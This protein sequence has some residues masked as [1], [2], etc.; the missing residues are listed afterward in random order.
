MTARRT[1]SDDQV[2]RRQDVEV[3]AD[4]VIRRVVEHRYT[5]QEDHR[6]Q[7]KR[8]WPAD[9]R[10]AARQ[11]AGHANAARGE[12][13]VWLIGVDED[14]SVQSVAEAEFANWWAQVR[15][16]FD[17]SAPTCRVY[18]R[19]WSNETI[20]VL[21]METG[22]APFV[23]KTGQSAPSRE[24][25]WMERGTDSASRRELL[26]I[27]VPAVGAPEIE[28]L[29][30]AL[31]ASEFQPLP[32]ERKLRGNFNAHLYFCARATE[33]IFFACHHISVEAVFSGS[34]QQEV[35]AQASNCKLYAHASEIGRVRS[36]PHELEVSGSGKVELSGQIITDYAASTHPRVRMNIALRATVGDL[37]AR[38]VVE[39][40]IGQPDT[41]CK[42]QWIFR[43]ST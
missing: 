33:P 15:S 1:E 2:M 25:P 36:S 34:G 43:K 4:E 24:V 28:V 41:G 38:V 13:I 30:G 39:G 29:G 19:H 11:I 5:K 17:E 22:A 21:H 14:G 12:D 23:V 31:P 3:L 32:G 26:K 7:L 18:L 40:E 10:K 27:L 6:V 35:V 20:P 37:V 42:V 8:E 16:H 9:P